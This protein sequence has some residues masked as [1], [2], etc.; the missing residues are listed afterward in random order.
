LDTEGGCVGNGSGLIEWSRAYGMGGDTRRWRPIGEGGV[1]CCNTITRPNNSVR[2]NQQ[3]G[4]EI[5][6]SGSIVRLYD[7]HQFLHYCG[8]SMS[9][10]SLW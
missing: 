4:E 5:L 6:F 7:G 8:T 2:I 9:A 10:D 3:N 1:R